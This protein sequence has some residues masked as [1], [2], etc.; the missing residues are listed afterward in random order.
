LCTL[1]KQW[2][3][4]HQINDALNGYPNNYSYILLAVHY[5][6]VR[7]VIPNLQSTMPKH[8][9]DD[10]N[11]DTLYAQV[12]A[13]VQ[14]ANCNQELPDMHTPMSKLVDGELSMHWRRMMRYLS[15]LPFET[16]WVSI[17]CAALLDRAHISPSNAALNKYRTIIEDPYEKKNTARCLIDEQKVQQVNELMLQ[18]ATSTDMSELFS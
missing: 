11:I 15:T 12:C 16:H 6:Q 18:A 3:G 2:A 4:R 5:M 10:H 8:F 7:N 14:R 13:H 17:R 1:I 9:A